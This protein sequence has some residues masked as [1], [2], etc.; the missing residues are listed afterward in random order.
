MEIN[1]F[2]GAWA[3]SSVWLTKK[4]HNASLAHCYIIQK[5]KLLENELQYV[6]AGKCKA[7]AT[8]APWMLF[9]CTDC[10]AVTHIDSVALVLVCKYHMEPLLSPVDSHHIFIWV[11]PRGGKSWPHEQKTTVGG[12][13][14]NFTP[15]TLQA[16]KISPDIWDR[17]Q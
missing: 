13:W 17:K 8:S 5:R 10:K 3:L 4:N 2:V 15:I 6:S 14:T 12:Q 16:D 1:M 9:Y 7:C 11:E